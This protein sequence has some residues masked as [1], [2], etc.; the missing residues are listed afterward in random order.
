MKRTLKL[1]VVVVFVVFFG[2][3]LNSWSKDIIV[4]TNQDSSKS[5]F[6]IKSSDA[7]ASYVLT[8]GV[9]DTLI[10]WDPS[11]REYKPALAEKWEFVAPTEIVFHLKKNIQYHD[12]RIFDATHVATSFNLIKKYT[13]FRALMLTQ[14]KQISIV[15]SET[16]VLR[17]KQPDP[18]ILRRLA[19]WFRI[20]P[21][22]TDPQK[23]FSINL[24]GTGVWK[25]IKNLDSMFEY[26]KFPESANEQHVSLIFHANS[27][28][29]DTIQPVGSEKSLIID[30]LPWTEQLRAK[31][32]LGLEII[33]VPANY[34]DFVIFNTLA[35]QSI[36]RDIRIRKAVNFAIDKNALTRLVY[37]NIVTPLVSL[38]LPNEDGHHT[39]LMPYPY[40]INEAMNLVA[41][42]KR[43]YPDR[44][45][46]VRVGMQSFGK[47]YDDLT[48]F[49]IMSLGNIGIKATIVENYSVAEHFLKYSQ[50]VDIIVGGDPSPYGHFDFMVQNFFVP[51]SP[52]YASYDSQI[53]FLL[54]QSKKCQTEPEV[55]KLYA[56]IDR[57]IHE[58][59]L[60]V[61]GVQYNR[62]VAFD[63][64]IAFD[65]MYSTLLLMNRL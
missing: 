23:L 3:P 27:A 38:S 6:G 61:P 62:L 43:E 55:N 10:T 36:T 47:T 46:S 48:Q 44:E 60:S 42:Y 13:S 1:Y 8:S 45:L 57:R 53:I 33:N 18:L 4:Y 35:K 14:I 25:F 31:K 51:G 64:T 7:E 16:I 49:I 41:D 30:G 17:L 52:F 39:S 29:I 9:Y 65:P 40:D 59:Y 28:D 15:N 37:G 2:T 21:P 26:A 50:A 20:Y 63:R 32:D 34:S 5:E 22:I 56:Q 58:E 19:F 54:E 12:G 24:P 11:T